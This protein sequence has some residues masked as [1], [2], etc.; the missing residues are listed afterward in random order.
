MAS[1]KIDGREYDT[2]NISEEAKAQLGSLQFCELELQRLQVETAAYQ[3]AKMAYARALKEAIESSSSGTIKHTSST[4]NAQSSSSVNHQD[5]ID[6]AV[7][8]AA[9]EKTEKKSFFKGL[10]GKK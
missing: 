3:T 8:P 7:A 6:S 4:G 2:E 1:I 9:S 5:N 10:F